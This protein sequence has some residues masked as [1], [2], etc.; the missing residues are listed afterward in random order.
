MPPGNIAVITFSPNLNYFDSSGYATLTIG[1]VAG[2]HPGF[3]FVGSSA[4]PVALAQVTLGS[5]IPASFI[6]GVEENN[7]GGN[8]QTAITVT[9]PSP[10]RLSMPRHP[11]AAPP[12]VTFTTLP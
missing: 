2:D 1:G 10:V 4:T 11:L 3:G 5:A 7:V 6:M 12:Q 8:D 9:G